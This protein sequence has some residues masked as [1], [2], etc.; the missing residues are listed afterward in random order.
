M[1]VLVANARQLPSCR[2]EGADCFYG[3]FEGKEKEAKSDCSQP[4]CREGSY[5][6]GVGHVTEVP[7]LTK[8]GGYFRVA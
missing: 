7:F 1:A 5:M 3:L 6:E 4:R 8:G 2:E